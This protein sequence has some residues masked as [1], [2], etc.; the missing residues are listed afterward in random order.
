MP[1]F[2]WSHA[3]RGL[4]SAEHE[5]FRDTVRRFYAEEVEPH[6]TRWEAAG[7]FDRDLFR[8][9][10]AAGLLCPGIPQQYGGGGGDLL[11]HVICYEEHGYSPAGASLGEGLDTDTSAYMVLAAGTE[12]Q[13]RYWLPK[14]ASGEVVAEG[15]FTE[16]HSGS[17]MG[18]VRTSARRDGAHYVVN[19][20]KIWITNANHLDMC[21]LVA[22]TG[23]EG[24]SAALSLFLV[25]LSLPG[26]SR[27][28]PLKTLHRGCSNLGELHFEDVRVP[29]DQLL[30][31][32]E[33]LGVKHA[34]GALNIGRLAF[35][36]RLIAS[37]EL[38]LR[39]TLE[40]VRER[41][42]FGRRIFE[43]QH[44]Q[45]QLT[46]LKT[47]IEV[48]RA[49]VDRCLARALRGVL[50]PAE[51]SMAK[52]WTSELEGRVLDACVQLHGAMGLSDEHPIS[53][54]Y[55]AARTHRIL[56]GTSEMQRMTILKAL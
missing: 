26:V 11:H 36:A 9:A 24:E 18:A 20:S 2:D 23:R 37:C 52:L 44:T 6:V 32:R 45:F 8:R 29:A 14:Y 39:M 17:D 42:A 51:A 47:Q 53:R 49:F 28:K 31:A 43:F 25:D 1:A 27:G 41:R 38:A 19:G 55:T 48:G 16:P 10:G 40:Y 12:E 3:E 46:D 35:S 33:G 7:L 34:A 30:G 21:L 54:M 50:K 5:A 4:F 22:R 13:K 15:A 56:M